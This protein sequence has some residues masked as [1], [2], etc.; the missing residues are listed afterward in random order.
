MR[1]DKPAL[2]RAEIIGNLGKDPD[3]R[4]T[5]DGKKIAAFSVATT[6]RWRDKVSGERKEQTD[7]HRLRQLA[8]AI[9][10]IADKEG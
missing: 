5:A 7:W 10:A 6:E 9:R 1:C 8:A 4:H 3:I 2:N